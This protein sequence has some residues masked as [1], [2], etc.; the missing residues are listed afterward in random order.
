MPRGHRRL[1]RVGTVAHKRCLSSPDSPGASERHRILS[2]SCRGDS[3]ARGAREM[4]G[5]TF[6]GK[7]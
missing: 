7:N 2:P 4:R 3:D 6:G 5:G 1:N